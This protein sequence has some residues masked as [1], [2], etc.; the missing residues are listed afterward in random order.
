M[1]EPAA[2]ALLERL[3]SLDAVAGCFVLATCN[4]VEVYATVRAEHTGAAAI[5]AVETSLAELGG[6]DVRAHLVRA[7]GQDALRHLFRVAASLDSLIVGEP[8]I[9]GQ[10]KTAV[11]RAE[12]MGTLGAELREATRFALQ[13]AK[14]IRSETD[15]GAG[16]ASVPTAAVRLARQIFGDLA[17]KTV[18]LVGAGD[19]AQAAAKVLA[20]SGVNIVIANRSEDRAQRL[21]ATVGGRVARWDALE[22]CL[23]EADIVISSTSSPTFVITRDMVKRAQRSRNGRSLF[24]IDIAVP[25]DVEPGANAIET[26]Y[27]YDVDDL[28]RVVEESRDLRDAAASRAEAILCEELGRLDRERIARGMT[29]LI[30]GLRQRT[31]DVL[32]SE[33]ERSLRGKLQHLSASDRAALQAM[34]EAAANKLMHAPTIRLKA[35]AGAPDAGRQ[36]ACVCELFGLSPDQVAGATSTTSGQSG[37][38]CQTK[39]RADRSEQRPA[40]LWPLSLEYVR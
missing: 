7:T 14:R 1:D 25:R 13:T 21:Q 17:N 38:A 40:A 16:Q 33:V 34:V 23:V 15:I 6:E 26:V 32:Q 22:A 5:E 18:L 28:S 12:D 2:R 19:M 30:K 8:H 20:H 4:R 3:A 37:C 24:L 11:Q 35:L 36:A 27:V 29:P 10:L 9:L 31:R 39:T